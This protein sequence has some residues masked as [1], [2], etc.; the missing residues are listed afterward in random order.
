[1]LRALASIP[2]RRR[3]VRFLASR[4]LWH[5]RACLLF[6]IDRR[7]YRLRFYPSALSA[8][9][10]EDPADRM[11]EEE[12]LRALV[13]PGETVIDVG[14]NIGST[15]LACAAA[16]GPK[17]RVVALEPH[18]RTFRL[19]AGNV[20][21]NP[22]AVVEALNLGAGVEAGEL[23]FSDSRSDDMNRVDGSGPMRVA[24]RR[25][26]D[27]AV[28]RGLGEVSLLKIDV[29]GYEWSVLKG[30]ET[31]LGRCGAVHYE[32]FDRHFSAF[33][34]TADQVAAWLRDRGFRIARVVDARWS[35]VEG[36]VRSPE[37][38]NLLAARPGSEHA[39][40]AGI[41]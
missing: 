30:A 24:V 22:G 25:L 23:R 17:G 7:W 3:P 4:L 18:P 21:F 12:H 15:A 16:V 26:D 34:H 9:L 27:L 14:A 38:E 2:R 6:A 20:D 8:A 19:L 41:G 40:R 33:G 28:E 37:C 1:M 10:W 39:R 29:E 5:S 13:A 32:S 36:E 31:L 11:D 35:L